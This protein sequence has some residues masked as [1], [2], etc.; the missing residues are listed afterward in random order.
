LQCLKDGLGQFWSLQTQESENKA[1]SKSP[2]GEEFDPN[3]QYG[4]Q[5]VGFLLVTWVRKK[6]PLDALLDQ[7]D[8]T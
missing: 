5:S 1:L 7:Q 8:N 2:K 4:R 6:S 3:P